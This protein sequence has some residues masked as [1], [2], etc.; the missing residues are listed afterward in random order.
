MG[1]LF[2]NSIFNL[3]AYWILICL[4]QFL[5][6]GNLN[7]CKRNVLICTCVNI[8]IHFLFADYSLISIPLLILMTALLFS[9]QKLRDCLLLFPAFVIYLLFIIL[10]EGILTQLFPILG[11]KFT[12][13]NYPLRP[14]SV[15][16]DVTL[17]FLLILLGH[18]LKKYEITLRLTLKEIFGAI[19]LFFLLF[20]EGAIISTIR[21]EQMSFGSVIIWKTIFLLVFLLSSIYYIWGIINS[22]IQL[23]RQTL[24][25]NEKEYLRVQLD[26]LQDIKDNEAQV[27]HLRHD[28]NNHLAII[29]SLCNDGNY[30]EIK[31]YTE[32]LR[33]DIVLPGSTILT[34]NQIA[35]LV[36][37]SKLKTAKEH[38]IDFSFHGSLSRLSNMA[39]P[40]IC[41][42][43][44]NA[45]D[46][47]I[48]ACLTQTAP[49]IHTKIS[50]TPNYTVIQI[51]N[52]IS[53]KPTIRGNRI[54]TTKKDKE[55]HGYGTEIMK[56]IALKYKG[57]C[58]FHSSAQEFSVKIVLLNDTTV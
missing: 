43:L 6:N 22:R 11:R 20:V 19:T 4:I 46:N 58:S 30:D 23:Y 49:Y 26:A 51:V 18:L 54:A 7:L 35:D 31:N 48:E 8:F 25:R 44:S 40:D 39:A 45:Y 2:I 34:G 9:S 10:P 50:T 28:L 52:S 14:I 5:F 21:F 38:Q 37:H 15:I 56:R 41:G 24:A 17:L 55:A 53:Q 47:A 32:H 36:V 1:F 42:L 3:S 57:S 27:K 16:I 13:L 29:Q 12:V 33:N